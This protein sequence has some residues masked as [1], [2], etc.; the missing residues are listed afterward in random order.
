LLQIAPATL[1]KG[2]SLGL[3]GSLSAGVVGEWEWCACLGKI[4]VIN[5]K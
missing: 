2:L 3:A 1:E 4:S 5:L